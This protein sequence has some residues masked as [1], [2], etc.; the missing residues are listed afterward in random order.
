MYAD[1]QQLLNADE[2]HYSYC[3]IDITYTVEE[4]LENA[5]TRI[6]DQA[7]EKAAAGCIML[8]LTDRN[9]D[10]INLPIPAA[11]AVGAVQKRLVDNNL[12]CESNI[13]IETG[14]VRDAHQFAVLLGFGATAI[15]P[16]L[17]YESLV[18]MSDSKIIDKSYCEV[19]LAYR[20]AI[21]KGL[22]KIM[23]KMGI[24]TVASVSYTHL[25]LPTNREV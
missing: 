25:T 7:Q 15:Y 23:S 8:I 5:V 22:Y 2:A 17:A 19:T 12:R 4:G 10:E 6:C 11:M 14:S 3:K 18:A 20:K 24:S 1:M 16:Y 9:F 21:N 13:I